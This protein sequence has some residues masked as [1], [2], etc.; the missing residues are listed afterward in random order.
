MFKH[1]KRLLKKEPAKPRQESASRPI[2]PPGSRPLEHA[3]PSIVVPP[4]EAAIAA[5]NANK[6]YLGSVLAGKLQG[7]QLTLPIA[8]DTSVGTAPSHSSIEAVHSTTAEPS[9]AAL[10]P[11][12]PSTQAGQAHSRSTTAIHSVGALADNQTHPAASHRVEESGAS[13]TSSTGSVSRFRGHSPNGKD[14]KATLHAA[15]QRLQKAL[16]QGSKH[17]ADSAAAATHP[18]VQ[19]PS[20]TTADTSMTSQ[21]KPPLLCCRLHWHKSNLV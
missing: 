14:H 9:V 1:A 15:N 10:S 16:Q 17:T 12:Q 20:S 8:P 2:S 13:Y 21:G 4:T 18:S 11:A 3:G 5:V 6:G 19:T 7:Q